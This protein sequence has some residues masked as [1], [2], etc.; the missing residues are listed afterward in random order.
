M[1]SLEVRFNDM[2]CACLQP[3]SYVSLFVY[4]IGIAC[5]AIEGQGAVRQ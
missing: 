3:P 2:D 4:V 1:E 5:N